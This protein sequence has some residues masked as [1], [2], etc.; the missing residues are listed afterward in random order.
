MGRNTHFEMDLTPEQRQRPKDAKKRAQVVR[1]LDSEPLLVLIPIQK[2]SN[3]RYGDAP[4]PADREDE[5]LEA[6]Q[7]IMGMALAFPSPPTKGLRENYIQV[8]LPPQQDVYVDE[9]V[10]EAVEDDG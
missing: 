6:T 7:H 8:Q 1:P 10:F 9:E 4:A 2:D 3:V 5:R